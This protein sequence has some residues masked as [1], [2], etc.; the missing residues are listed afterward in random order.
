MT[1]EHNMQLFVTGH[2]I[3]VTDSMRAYVDKKMERIVR[4]FDHVI[5][6]HCI[7]SVEK[8]EQRAEATLKV[9]G[10]DIHA[11][12]IDTDMYAA[13]DALSDKLDRLVKKHKE[14]A[15]DHHAAEGRSARQ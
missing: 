9:R 7:L 6:V 5:D 14:K 8:L 15:S 11:D 2:H 10:K 13:I 4:H 1:E 3:E 12:A